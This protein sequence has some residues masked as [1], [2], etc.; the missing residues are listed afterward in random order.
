MPDHSST[1][2]LS[3]R[4]VGEP[5]EQR[6]GVCVKIPVMG[7]AEQFRSA[8]LV[9]QTVKNGGWRATAAPPLLTTPKQRAY[10]L[11]SRQR[12]RRPQRTKRSSEGKHA[13]SSSLRSGVTVPF[14]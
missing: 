8:G 4:R 10:Y 14:I 13:L 7:G 2:T 11:A 5:G 12:S 9:F 6:T 1:E 3:R